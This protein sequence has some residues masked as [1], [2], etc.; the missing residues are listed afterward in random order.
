MSDSPHL[1]LNRRAMRRLAPAAA[2]AVAL[3]VLA[4]V[5]VQARAPSLRVSDAEVSESAATAVFRIKL[6][7]KPRGAV[8]V[9]YST[10]DRTA[11]AGEDYGEV[12]GRMR[13]RRGTRVGLVEVPI[14]DDEIDEPDETFVL[15]LSS[16]RRAKLADRVG[17][18]RILDDDPGVG[19]PLGAL[20]IN[21]VDYDQ[22]GADEAEFVEIRNGSSQAVSLEGVELFLVNG[23]D[24]ASYAA[25]DLSVEGALAA[26]GYLVVAMAAVALPPDT[27]TIPMP[28]GTAMQNGPDGLALAL[29]AGEACT[30]IDAL[31][32]EG[33]LSGASLGGCAGT[34]DLVEGTATSA[35]DSNA[36]VGSLARL[37]DGS[38]T[39][40][41]ETD[42]AFTTTITPGAP[43]T[44]S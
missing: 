23:A 35:S 14:L 6:R 38:D 26:G 39:D 7:G 2:V 16:P 44:A 34:H 24:L 41:A 42:W 3:L 13:L 33:S 36:V 11:T 1:P 15:R 8:T 29:R 5:P 18:G 37:P 12:S 17:I 19:G 28:E 30:L 21:E 10:T 9:R 22:V 27:P 4:P 32:Y 25:L 40:E 20:V 43:N 31:S